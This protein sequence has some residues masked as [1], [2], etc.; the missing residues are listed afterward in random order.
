MLDFLARILRGAGTS[1]DVFPKKSS[2][3]APVTT[4]V[5]ELAASHANK[6]SSAARDLIFQ[7]P[8]SCHNTSATSGVIAGERVTSK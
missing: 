1:R 6:K 2:G 8:N 3:G 7:S 4:A 5:M